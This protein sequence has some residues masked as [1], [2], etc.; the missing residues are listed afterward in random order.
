MA[1]EIIEQADPLEL[2]QPE[3]LN[4][5]HNVDQF[6]CGEDSTNE[7][8]KKKALKAQLAKTAT[9]L[10]TCPKGSNV[11]VGY[12]TLSS[13]TIMRADVVPKKAQRNSPDQHPI[14]ILGRMGVCK[15]LQGQGLSLDLIQDAVLRSLAASEAVASTALV[16]HPLNEQLVGLYEK[17]GFLRSPQVSPIAMMLPLV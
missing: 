17:A 2:S 4:E 16:V 10:V 3:K 6:D 12:Y 13:G 8:L 14:T 7:F 15:T 1:T 9:V 11:V 5:H